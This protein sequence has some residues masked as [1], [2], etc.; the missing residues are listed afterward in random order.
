MTDPLLL[1]VPEIVSSLHL[2]P[3]PAVADAEVTDRLR[4]RLEAMEPSVGRDVAL[5]ALGSPILRVEVM[6]SRSSDLPLHLIELFGAAPDD[7]RQLREAR[8]VVV[9]EA[10]GQAGWPPLHEVSART[11]ALAIGQLHGAPILDT[12]STQLLAHDAV[13]ASLP[14]PGEPLILTKWVLV[15]QSAG[16]LGMWMTTKGLVRFGLP[17]LEVPDVPPQMANAWTAILSGI[18]RALIDRYS[19]ALDAAR[20]DQDQS[21]AFVEID[22]HL[23]VQL[24]DI[25]RAYG[26]AEPDEDRRSVVRLEPAPRSDPNS[27]EFLT[28]G[29]PDSYARSRAEFYGE[30]GVDLFGVEDHEVR[31]TAPTDELDH[32]MEVAISCLDVARARFLAG[33]FEH[34]TLLMVKWRLAADDGVEYPWAFVTDWSDAA[35]LRA[36]SASDADRDPLVRVGR[37][38]VLDRADVVDWAVWVDGDGVIEGGWTNAV[39]EGLP[40]P[41]VPT[42]PSA[43]RRRF[44]RRRS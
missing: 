19:E 22:R 40:F 33:E 25:A 16:E 8:A 11:A 1:A 12:T 27:D 17:E 13:A 23:Q 36:N 34:R 20:R 9:V 24:A 35:V 21:P 32:A 39:L 38:L 44:G 6:P 18:A 2:V 7:L 5:H 41:P 3:W 14:A 26:D 43:P 28:V 4:S 30:V 29:P 31:Y 42:V 37:P 10:L 15:P